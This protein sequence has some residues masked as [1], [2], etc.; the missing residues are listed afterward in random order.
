MADSSTNEPSA[1]HFGTGN[2]GPFVQELTSEI[3]YH[4]FEAHRRPDT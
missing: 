1:S 2:I 4:A 3:M